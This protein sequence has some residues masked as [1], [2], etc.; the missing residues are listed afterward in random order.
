MNNTLEQLS[1][2]GVFILSGIIISIF[3]DLFRVLRKTFKTPDIL[4]YIEDVI[5]WLVTGLFL[6][7]I[8]FRFNNGELRLY[9]FASLFIGIIIYMFTL[10]K[11]FILINSKILLILIKPFS[12][13]KKAFISIFNIFF[14]TFS[15]YL[16]KKK[17]N[18]KIS[19]N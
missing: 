10:S 3:F 6:I 2:V 5:F 12:L 15:K 16:L 17:N 7:L 8:I 13:I 18:G 1:S 11:Y 19:K 9:M 14:K 4:T